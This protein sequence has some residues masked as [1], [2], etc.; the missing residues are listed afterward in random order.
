VAGSLTSGPREE[1]YM[2]RAVM[3][4]RKRKKRERERER[5]RERKREV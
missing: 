1:S 5:E 3:A 4:E 2:N